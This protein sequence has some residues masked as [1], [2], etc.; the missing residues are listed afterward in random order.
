MKDP[1]K[2]ALQQLHDIAKILSLEDS[3]IERLSSIERFVEVS[4]PIR[5]DDGSIKMFTGYRSQ[6]NSALGPYKGGLRFSPF[7]NESE[8]KALSM[9][10]SWKC[11]V[12][13]LPYG[14]G[15]GGVI[16][17]T[18]QL[19]ETELERL[20]RAFMRSIWNVIGPD[21][22]IP[23]PDMYTTPQIMLWM[24]EEYAKIVGK[25]TPAVITAKPLDKGGS[26]GRTEA[27][28]LGGFY[29]LEQLAKSKK[30]QPSKTTIAVQGFGNVGY[31]FAYFAHKAG[32]K[33][34]ALSDSKGGVYNSKGI[35]IIKAW[36]YKNAHSSFKGFKQAE[37]ITNEEL[38]ESKATVLVPSA[39]ENVVTEK[40][41]PRLKTKYIIELANGPVTPEADRI[42]SKRNIISIP[43]ILANAGGVTV[44]YF[45]WFQNKSGKHWTK[46][47]VFSMLRDSLSKSFRDVINSSRK[48]KKDLRMGAYALA[49]QKVADA[50][51]KK[52]V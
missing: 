14:G 38:L 8:V 31:Y 49:V 7:V 12:A 3:M 48:I 9:W 25:W 4:F 29:I 21:T 47:K 17:D 44:S 2:N 41:A 33:I 34:I 11:A 39:V 6:H 1:Y 18:K 40:N 35:D 51:K 24:A 20:S 26:Q 30:L 10:M 50:L 27:T 32:F 36:D 22:D 15:K 43:D 52:K 45:E 16:V 37:T 46:K 13:R 42:L 5:M 19:S 28:G 23:A